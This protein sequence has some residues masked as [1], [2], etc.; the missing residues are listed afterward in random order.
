M[1]LGQRLR[2][3]RRQRELT[4]RELAQAC[5]L[6]VTY[7]SDVERDRTRPSIKTLRRIAVAVGATLTELL[8]DTEEAGGLAEDSLP[9]GLRELV[10][11]PR[12]GV[13]LD[14]EWLRTLARVD[15]RGRRPETAD[16]W[17]ELYLSLRRLLGER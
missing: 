9:A 5:E 15:Y 7:L 6:S 8:A 2:E 3:R 10:Q 4:L 1:T 13:Q 11:D 14:E 17:L 16:E 12:W